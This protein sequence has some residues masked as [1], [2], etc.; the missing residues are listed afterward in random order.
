MQNFKPLAYLAVGILI[1]AIVSGFCFMTLGINTLE[2]SVPIPEND[3]SADQYAGLST[4]ENPMA[5]LS[6]VEIGLIKKNNAN[7]EA[8]MYE[9][10]ISHETG[11]VLPAGVLKAQVKSA[12]VWN[13]SLIFASVFQPN[14]NYPIMGEDGEYISGPVEFAGIMMSSDGGK[15][16]FE[17]MKS[18]ENS[19]PIAMY[20]YGKRL[21][22]DFI[23]A[24]G[25][26]SGE[27][28]LQRFSTTTGTDWKLDYCAYYIPEVY[29]VELIRFP[30]RPPTKFLEKITC[31]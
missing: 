30:G 25:A 24:D 14:M 1:G 3:T 31:P 22:I 26:G 20:S 19:N 6:Q 11:W 8:A 23:G 7:I 9:L 4:S 27:G 16:W 15:T 5:A 12:Y 13:N 18:P 29:P 2:T 21:Y 10:I 17:L 28:T